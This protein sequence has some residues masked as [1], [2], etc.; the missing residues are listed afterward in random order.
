[1]NT[2]TCTT[3]PRT[4]FATIKPPTTSDPVGSVVEG[5]YLILDGEVVLTDRDGK[6]VQNH[7][8]K[9]YR[10]KLQPGDDA[11]VHARRLTKQFRLAR[12]TKNG[13]VAGF[14]GPLDYPKTGWL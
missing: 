12:R 7:D 14:G 3:K 10:H 4:V 8:G 6:P 5:C 13:A 11:D 9:A 2:K 1:M